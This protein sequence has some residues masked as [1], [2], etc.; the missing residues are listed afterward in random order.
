MTYPRHEVRAPESVLDEHLRE[1]EKLAAERAD[2]D[3]NAVP[4]G[5]REDFE[6]LRWFDL[7]PICLTP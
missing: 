1:A 6:A 5:L 3:C 4:D 2:P 7:P